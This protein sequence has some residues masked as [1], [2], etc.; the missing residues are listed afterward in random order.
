MTCL[1]CSMASFSLSFIAKRRVG[2]EVALVQLALWRLRR[3]E[4]ILVSYIQCSRFKRGQRQLD[5]ISHL[6]LL[7]CLSWTLLTIFV[8]YIVTRLLHFRS[9]TKNQQGQ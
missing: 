9:L 4:G 6:L 1:K 8:L 3:K 7:I 5:S 2:I